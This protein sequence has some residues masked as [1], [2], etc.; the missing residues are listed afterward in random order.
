MVMSLPIAIRS[1]DRGAWPWR[2]CPRA[3]RRWS[4]VPVPHLR[5]PAEQ[6]GSFHLPLL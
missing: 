1:A 4:A 2:R 6:G 3:G 5:H